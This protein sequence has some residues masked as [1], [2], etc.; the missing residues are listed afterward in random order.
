MG[1]S[2]MRWEEL[3]YKMNLKMMLDTARHLKA[4]LPRDHVLLQT[5]SSSKRHSLL[6][7][8]DDDHALVS[9]GGGD[10]SST[11]VEKSLE[12]SQLYQPFG[13]CASCYACFEAES[14][15][16]SVEEELAATLGVP[17]SSTTSAG[18]ILTDV[19][20]HHATKERTAMPLS[21][22]PQSES[23]DLTLCRV[24]VLL[25]HL[26]E[27]ALSAL[28]TTDTVLA[29][30]DECQHLIVRYSFLG[31]M[32]IIRL[33]AL[34]SNYS[35]QALDDAVADAIPIQHLRVHYFMAAHTPVDGPLQSGKGLASLLST[36]SGANITVEVLQCVHRTINPNLKATHGA[37]PPCV[38]AWATRSGAQNSGTSDFRL[39]TGVCA[40]FRFA[41]L[42]LR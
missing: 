36:S 39:E 22:I 38:N 31:S 3:P 4:R 42:V 35:S 5:A 24:V 13:V 32:S 37:S 8:A 26:H 7:A 9:D 25:H 27:L 18:V 11:Q 41:L 14:K 10:G 29:K 19:H 20:Q 2:G 16:A 30:R 28:H 21:A 23:G 40:H 1:F 6:H 15:L 33:P 12:S 17:R 34:P